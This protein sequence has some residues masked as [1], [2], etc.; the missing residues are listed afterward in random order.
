MTKPDLF[1]VALDGIF[2]IPAPPILYHYTSHLGLLG[3]LKEKVI[4]ASH[5]RYLNDRTEYSLAFDYAEDALNADTEI[6]TK[7]PKA[8]SLI[9]PSF[10]RVREADIYVISF[11][12]DGGD[13][14]SQWR[15]YCQSGG[16]S[17]G[18]GSHLIMGISDAFSSQHSYL[19]SCIYGEKAIKESI[20]DLVQTLKLVLDEPVSGSMPEVRLEQALIEF[21]YASALVASRSK[22]GGFN[23]EKEWRLVIRAKRTTLPSTL[24]FHMRQSSIVPHLEVPL[25]IPSASAIPGVSQLNFDSIRVGPC[26][27][28]DEGVRAIEMLLAK[29]GA[30]CSKVE[31]CN[32][33]FRSW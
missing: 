6:S 31:Q 24:A 10:E 3:M 32:I 15:G 4:W 13:R 21:A 29:Y 23:E 33:P 2:G 28:P 22:H 18:F 9:K 8:P 12:D 17:L 25:T 1:D 7:Y 14:L 11:S 19:T 26:P 30:T 16:Y 5:V 27:H 20:S